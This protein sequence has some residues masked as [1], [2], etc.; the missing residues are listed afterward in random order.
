ME[1][2]VGRVLREQNKTVAVCEDLTCG[3][4]GTAANGQ[5]RAFRRGFICNNEAALRALLKNSAIRR[6]S[7]LLKDPWR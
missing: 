1:H 6:R 3:I 5:R 4:G 7:T 2:V